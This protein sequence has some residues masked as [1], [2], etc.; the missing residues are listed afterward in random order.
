MV[1]MM[2]HYM[3]EKLE[4]GDSI[5]VTLQENE[6]GELYVELTEE[7]IKELDLNVDE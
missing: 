1:M 6:N 3:E 7:E 4:D 5:V 2:Y